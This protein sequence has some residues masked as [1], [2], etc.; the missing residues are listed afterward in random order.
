MKARNLIKHLMESQSVTNADMARKLGISP[1]AM[2]ERTKPTSKKDIGIDQFMT[3][4]GQLGYK[5]V[6]IPEESSIPKKAYIID[7]PAS[8]EP[9][10]RTVYTLTTADG[11]VWKFDTEDEA[12]RNKY[13]FGGRIKKEEVTQ[14][15]A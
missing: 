13:I 10:K 3:A 2:Y 8:A 14:H 15:N 5:I 1:Q 12:K 11:D 6:A 4:I 7:A 9:K